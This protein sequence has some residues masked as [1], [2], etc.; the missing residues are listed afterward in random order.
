[1]SEPAAPSDA[2]YQ[3]CQS[4]CHEVLVLELT[5]LID[6]SYFRPLYISIYLNESRM[7]VMSQECLLIIAIVREII[8]NRVRQGSPSLKSLE[9]S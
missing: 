2:D 5:I 4:G 1:M 6:K 9:M 7:V 8:D 3:A